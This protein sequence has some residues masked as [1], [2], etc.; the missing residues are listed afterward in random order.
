MSAS[1]RVDPRLLLLDGI[2]PVDASAATVGLKAANLIRMAQAGLPVPPGFVLT[3]QV[4]ADYYEAGG[5]LDTELTEL[6]TRAVGYIERATGRSFGAQRHPL[7]VSARSGA[8]VS[9][10]GM[11][12]TVLNIGLCDTTLPGLLRATGDPVFVWDCYRRLISAYAETVERCSPAPFAAVTDEAL[13]RHRVPDASELDVAALRELVGHLTDTYQSTVGRPFPQDPAQ[14]LMRAVE[15]VLRSWNAE[16]A[17]A[18]RRMQNLPDDGGT[19]VTV[20]A[21]VFGNMG[22]TS[23]SGVGFTR[24]PATGANELYLDYL[25]GRQGEDIV[26]GRH[27]AADPAQLIAAVPGLAQHLETVRHTLENVFGDAQDFE[28]TV[29]NGKLWL[30]QTR[31]AKRTPWA[32]LQV[33]CDLVDEQLIDPSTALD[34]LRPYDLDHITRTR[35]VTKPETTPIGRATPA[36]T[37]VATGRI[38]LHPDT[39]RQHAEHSQPTILVREEAS[40]DDVAALAACRG[41]L[42]ATGARTCHAAVVARQLGIVCL[43]NCAELHIDTQARRLRIGEHQLDEDDTITIDGATGNIYTGA[44]Q[45]VEDHP[46]DLIQRVRA[47]A[48]GGTD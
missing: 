17:V 41:L 6:I 13:R 23:G 12:D 11:L 40:T 27:A 14:Q 30:L 7:L 26:A 44:L 36:S 10:P 37:G 4:C 48:R 38:A 9:M 25:P 22:A 45:I 34:R 15:A 35:L 29:E 5:R 2:N 8:P 16:R 20:Q 21:M 24:D 32:A 43:V 47:W 39:A 19:A 42:T 1:G 33:A 3:T 18:Y 31:A 28:F 46:T